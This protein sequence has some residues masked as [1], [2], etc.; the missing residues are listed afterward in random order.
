MFNNTF[1]ALSK[2]AGFAFEILGLGVTQI[3]KANYARK[4][5]YYQSFINL[6]V[7]L[8]RL[9]KICILL[10]FYIQNNGNFPSDKVLRNIGHNIQE[11]YN[12][13]KEIKEFYKFKF[14]YLDNLDDVIHQNILR[15]LSDFATK[16]RYE[17]LNILVN[18]KQDNNPLSLW[19][20]QV[21]LK[22]FEKYVSKKKQ[23]EILNNAKIISAIMS[24][25]S[26]ISFSDENDDNINTVLDG[27]IKTGVYEAVCKKR[28]LFLAQIVRFWVELIWELQ[29]KAMDLGKEEIPFFNDMFGCFYNHDS[30]FK[31]I[32]NYEI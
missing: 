9:A 8:E 29:Y 11:L 27:S 7:G 14:K 22:L 5:I 30:Y 1:N 19:Y 10:D 12:K 6:S 17:N 31:T 24:P 13:S 26:V 20:K 21:D 23:E 15:I 32:V 18:A 25:F 28:Q 4:G 16:D 3:K 2:E